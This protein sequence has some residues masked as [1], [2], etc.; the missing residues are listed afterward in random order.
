M[1]RFIVRKESDIGIAIVG[2]ASKARALGFSSDQI[3]RISTAISELGN[4]I[5]KYSSRSGGDIVVRDCKQVNGMLRLVVLARDN[6]PGITDIELALKDHYSSSG[7][8]G[9]GLPGV[10]RIVDAF[11]II[12]DPGV[13]TVVTIEMH[14]KINV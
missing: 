4:N 2:V 3:G 1:D 11:N 10:R 14:G 8:L 5:V 7:T 9:L 12:S 6:G 13:G